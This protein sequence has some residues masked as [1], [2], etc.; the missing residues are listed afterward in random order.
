M[1]AEQRAVVAAGHQEHSD[2][3]SASDGFSRAFFTASFQWVRSE[4]LVEP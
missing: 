1:R 2:R 4:V 3:S